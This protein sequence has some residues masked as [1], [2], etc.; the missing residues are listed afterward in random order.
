MVT[1]SDRA[2]ATSPEE[3]ANPVKFD[4]PMFS[5]PTTAAELNAQLS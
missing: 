4:F 1:L 2:A 5:K 3:H